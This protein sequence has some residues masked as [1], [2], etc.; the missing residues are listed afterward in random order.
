MRRDI[1]TR[2]KPGQGGPPATR[3]QPGQSGNPAGKPRRRVLFE[4]AFYDALI[5]EGSAEEAAKLLWTCA[6]AKEP[7]AVQTLLQRLAPQDVRLKVTLNEGSTSGQYDLTRLTDSELEQFI[8]LAS[9][10]RGASETEL[11]AAN[12][13]DAVAELPAGGEGETQVP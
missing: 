5:G 8:Q 6:R 9:R 10:A 12:T 2:F 3:W 13:I 11:E 7:W 1:A 4:Q